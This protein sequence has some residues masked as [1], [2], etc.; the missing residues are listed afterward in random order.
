MEQPTPSI[1]DAVSNAAVPVSAPPEWTPLRIARVAAAGLAVAVSAWL[2]SITVWSVVHCVPGELVYDGMGGAVVDHCVRIREGRPIYAEPDDSFMPLLY[3]P[4]YYYLCTATMTVLGE[5]PVACRVT[6]TVLIG[7]SVVVLM[8]LVRRITRSNWAA[9]LVLPM[10]CAAYGQTRFYFTE[11]RVDPAAALMIMLSVWSA[12]R[13]RGL[14]A[15]I[16]TGV[17]LS[18]AFW[19]K[20]STAIFSAMFLLG[21]LQD[22]FKRAL[23]A[24]I[25]FGVAVLLSTWTATRLTDG[26]F[27]T[28]IV[29]LGR[30]HGFPL[31]RLAR[32]A[33]MDWAGPLLW[34]ALAL[35]TLLV[36]FTATARRPG[37][38]KE[39]ERGIR[40][41][42]T[43]ILALGVYS[44]VSR[45][46]V[47]STPKPLIPVSLLMA[48]AIPIGLW[49]ITQIGSSL[50]WRRSSAVLV[51][52]L[53]AAYLYSQVFPV[54]ESLPSAERAENWARIMAKVCD[55]ADEGPVWVTPFGYVT[56]RMPGQQMRPTLVAVEDYVGGR[57]GPL[58][59][60]EIP[61]PLADKI[62]AGYFH[63]IVLP[64]RR[65][66]RPLENL[67]EQ[68]YRV[69]TTIDGLEDD[70]APASNKLG[71][72]RPTKKLKKDPPPR[73]AKNR[74]PPP[75]R[76]RRGR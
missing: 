73:R 54:S 22:G 74:K 67:L 57:F 6:S 71:F 9:L 50:A 48:G 59:G 38:G 15:A 1:P 24:A 26:W 20:Q 62:A 17:F 47:G 56:T 7:L 16:L 58:T 12:I 3:T 29:E 27:W 65:V 4:L 23:A 8:S 37:P 72:F 5:G 33:R 66:D 2:I 10:A 76:P 64:I 68:Y 19:S 40:L 45:A 21:L 13:F 42:I 69:E 60:R 46:N 28:F 14:A 52:C 49:R 63:T 32:T 61:P 25:T 55:A 18:L 70:T 51:A 31:E 35:P 30:H 36:S 53:A 11:P 75:G 41:L 34:P 39:A 44:L 43:S